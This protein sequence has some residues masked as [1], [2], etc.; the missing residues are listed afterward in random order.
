MQAS[1][2]F[3][4]AVHPVHVSTVQAYGQL[5]CSM[6]CACLLS[7]VV[8]LVCCLVPGPGTSEMLARSR[9]WRIGIACGLLMHPGWTLVAAFCCNHMCAGM[10]VLC[11][12]LNASKLLTNARPGLHRQDIVTSV[13]VLQVAS[14]GAAVQP[15]CRMALP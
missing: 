12:V 1:S 15:G 3:N 6:P 7:A 2:W 13:R 5:S 10:D 9:P 4:W 8:A 11:I 14:R